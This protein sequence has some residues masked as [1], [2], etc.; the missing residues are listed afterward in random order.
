MMK[1]VLFVA[2]IGMAAVAAKADSTVSYTNSI[3]LSLTDWTNSVSFTKFNPSLGVLHSMSVTLNNGL[4]TI[5]SVTNG[6]L[7]SSSGTA[8]TT[9]DFNLDAGSYNLFGGGSQA[10][11]APNVDEYNSPG[12]GYSLDPGAGTTSG[13]LTKTHSYTGSSIT[14]STTLDAF[15]GTGSVDLT[16]WTFTQTDLANSGGNTAESQITEASADYIV[17][18]DF[19]PAPAPEPS[20]VAMLGAGLAGLGMIFRRRSSK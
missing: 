8:K 16:A 10:N 17:T 14:D 19:T 4:S 1:K 11:G 13:V 15:T 6:A 5:I 9:I 3:A 7:S 12:Y 18:Y 2:A 20:A